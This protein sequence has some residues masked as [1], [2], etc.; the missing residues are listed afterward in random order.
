MEKTVI[1][2]D[3]GTSGC[4][5]LLLDEKGRVLAQA[6][7]GYGVHTPFAGCFEQDPQTWMEAVWSAVGMLGKKGSLGQVAGIGLSG[8]MHGLVLLDGQ[9][10]LLRP[11]ILWCDQ[12]SAAHSRRIVDIAGGQAQLLRLTGTPM[13]SSYTAGRLLWVREE[14][15]QVYERAQHVLCPKDYVRYRLTSEICTDVSDASGTGLFDVKNRAWSGALLNMLGIDWGWMPRSYESTEVVGALTA[16][17]ATRLGLSPGLPV[18]AGGGDALAQSLGSGLIDEASVGITIGTGGQVCRTLDTY[19]LHKDGN[20]QLFCN[21]IPGKWHLMGV[22]QSAGAVLPW[23]AGILYGASDANANGK[24]VFAEMDAEAALAPPGAD[25][26]L[27]LPYINGE[28]C[29]HHDPAARGCFVGLTSAHGRGHLL[30][31]ALEGV[32]FGMRE[33]FDLVTHMATAD[34]V[35]ISGGGATSALWRQIFADVL[36]RELCT[37]TASA[38]GAAYG[39]AL[40]AGVG[41]GVWDSLATGTALLRVSGCTPCQ[42]QE[43]DI[44]DRLFLMYQSLYPA[45][46]QGIT[47]QGALCGE[48]TRC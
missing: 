38:H 47:A 34:R 1:G 7:S 48:E 44:Y 14:E 25:G 18:V 37:V 32:A 10:E 39:A 21:V 16:D 8:Q 46:R 5:A 35:V 12:R 31:S 28:R 11:C 30:R 24:S 3:V 27:F 36:Q 9:G 33:I 26:L 15:P 4:K 6:Y 40:L 2:I 29:P 19:Q 23:L 43:K 20:L 17:A 45:I 41:V 42:A 13:L 22:M